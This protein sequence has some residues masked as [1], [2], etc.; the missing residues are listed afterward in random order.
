MLLPSASIQVALVWRTNLLQLQSAPCSWQPQPSKGQ[1]ASIGPGARDVAHLPPELS[2][3]PR[4]T[5]FLHTVRSTSEAQYGVA[6]QSR[7]FPT[8]ARRALTYWV[9]PLSPCP[10]SAHLPRRAAAAAAHRHTKILELQRSLPLP[11]CFPSCLPS[12]PMGVPLFKLVL[13]RD[14]LLEGSLFCPLG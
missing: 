5:A 14:M 9:A 3:N 13:S 6:T 7:V 4:N 1:A 10:I 11:A 12:S 2:S 8:A